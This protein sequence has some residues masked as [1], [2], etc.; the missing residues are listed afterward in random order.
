M[1][2]IIYK[3]GGSSQCFIGY[4]N[5]IEILN[6]NNNNI[7]VISAIKGVTNNLINFIKTKDLNYINEVEKINNFIYETITTQPYE[8]YINSLYYLKQ[9]CINFINGSNVENEIIGYGE[10]LSSIIFSV[11][12]TVNNID[13]ELLY[14]YNHVY[15]NLF[16]EF[17]IKQF[18]F[19]NNKNIYVIQ[20]FIASTESNEKILLGRGGS[21]TTGALLAQNLKAKY[22]EV[23][24]D[25]DGI[26]TCDPK[27]YNFAKII[28]EIDYELCQELSAMGAK[29]MHPLS[30][31]PCQIT[32]IP[33]YIRNTFTKNIGTIICKPFFSKIKHNILCFTIQKNVTVFKIKSLNMWNSCGFITQ[34]FK[35]FSD[36]NV[37]VNIVATSQFSVSTTT[38]EENYNKLFEIKKALSNKFNV[39]IISNCFILSYISNNIHDKLNKINLTQF[40]PEIIHFSDNNLSISIVLKDIT[41]IYNLLYYI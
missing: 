34:I 36:R 10:I 9:L 27:I 23:W 12:L 16:N 40:N 20:G 18:K 31:R 25:V 2:T 33:I 35:E 5:L 41:S 26:Y 38:F 11:F 13:H 1:N 14:A 28:P 39:S 29:V 37:D 15:S 7:I 21:D 30:I 17:Y 19:I 22:Y 6:K 4:K 8:V 32:N 3:L 24:T